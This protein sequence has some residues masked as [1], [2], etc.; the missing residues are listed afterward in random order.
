MDLGVDRLFGVGESG[1]MPG[2]EGSVRAMIELVYPLVRCGHSPV[3]V[4][5]AQEIM[6]PAEHSECHERAELE[7]LCAVFSV[8]LEQLGNTILTTL[9]MY[10]ATLDDENTLDHFINAVERIAGALPEA[11]DTSLIEAF[12]I[13]LLKGFYDEE[14]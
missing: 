1:S 11:Y 8:V 14:F 5:I 13:G 10:L 3:A 2:T 12:H 7:K 9:A 6:V 4:D